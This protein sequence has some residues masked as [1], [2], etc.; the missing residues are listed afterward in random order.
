MTITTVDQETK[1]KV[2]A[3]ILALGD[4]MLWRRETIARECQLDMNTTLKALQ[5]LKKEGKVY[6]EYGRDDDGFLQG[7]GWG[8]V[9][10]LAK[11]I[12]QNKRES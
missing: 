9:Y 4:D 12:H 6:T 11:A 8:V 7:R 1:D 10:S 2:Y 3:E 5:E